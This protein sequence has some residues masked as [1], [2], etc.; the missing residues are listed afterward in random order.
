[1]LTYFLVKDRGIINTELHKTKKSFINVFEE[2]GFWGRKPYK[3]NEIY[4]DYKSATSIVFDMY[5]DEVRSGLTKFLK[6]E[7]DFE[8]NDL[9]ETNHVLCFDFRKKYPIELNID[10]DVAKNALDLDK[11]NIVFD[12]YNKN[13]TDEIEFHN[14]AYHYQRKNRFWR[15]TTA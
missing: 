9:I 11:T 6:E 7:F 10:R 13:I 12:H 8:N 14:I 15:C 4:W 3:G 2:G 5:R 1:M